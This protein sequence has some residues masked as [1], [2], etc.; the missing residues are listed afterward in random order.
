MKG[1]VILL[2]LLMVGVVVLSG[3]V[4]PVCNK[5]YILV[6]TSCCLDQNNNNVC[7]SEDWPDKLYE[8]TEY[9][10]SIEY[11]EGWVTNEIEVGEALVVFYGDAKYRY[12][13]ISILISNVSNSTLDQ[14]VEEIKQSNIDK[15]FSITYNNYS[16]TDEGVLTVS[17]KNAYF[18]EYKY[19]SD[20]LFIRKKDVLLKDG[21]TMYYVNY[22]SRI[23]KYVGTLAAFDKSVS[24]FKIR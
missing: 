24:T 9:G 18:I 13:Y 4:E 15:W 11:P 1:V 5:P 8:N 10:F 7:D 14:H 16:F 3:C 12:P 20:G 21:D 22:V 2:G 6:G 17:G 19:F 23:D